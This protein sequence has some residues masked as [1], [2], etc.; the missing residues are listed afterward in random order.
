IAEPIRR[1]LKRYR[2]VSVVMSEVERIDTAARQVFT[3][4]GTQYAY[5]VLVLATGS[6]YSYFGHDDWQ[7]YAIGL[8]TI[9][10]A[11]LIRSRLLSAYERAEKSDDPE[12]Q[13]RLLTTVVIGG[14]PTGV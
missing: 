12:E 7:Q 3:G 13:R 4:D 2:N 14:G 11:R 8:K 9:E 1:V 10:N 6:R 5:D